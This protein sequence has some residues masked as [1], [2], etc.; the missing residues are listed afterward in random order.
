MIFIFIIIII[1]IYFIINLDKIKKEIKRIREE[2]NKILPQFSS[3][4]LSDKDK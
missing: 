4:N 3:K 1:F 2:K